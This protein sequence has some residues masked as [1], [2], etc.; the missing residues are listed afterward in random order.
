MNKRITE[1]AAKIAS[2]NPEVA[3]ELLALA[4]TAQGK[5]AVSKW[6]AKQVTD[7]DVQHQAQLYWSPRQEAYDPTMMGNSSART[8]AAQVYQSLLF[9]LASEFY[10]SPWNKDQAKAVEQTILESEHPNAKSIA[11]T[12]GMSV[13]NSHSGSSYPSVYW[14]PANYSGRLEDLI[15]FVPQL[16]ELVM[17]SA[18]AKV[19]SYL[20]D[21]ED[22]RNTT[23]SM[24]ERSVLSGL[25]KL[26]MA[27]TLIGDIKE[28]LRG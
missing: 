22:I 10:F 18:V 23:E 24:V 7:K 17:S 14:G 12:V 27:K 20:N 25:A 3:Y 6:K 21:V 8:L 9:D 28:D 13:F 11:R 19:E 2:T 15:K 1:F 16:R 26:G 5:T 4:L